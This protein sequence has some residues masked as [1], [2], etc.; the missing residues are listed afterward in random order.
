MRDPPNEFTDTMHDLCAGVDGIS[1]ADCLTTN[2]QAGNDRRHE[3]AEHLRPGKRLHTRQKLRGDRS[4]GR[5]GD[6][7]TN[8]ANNIVADG[9]DTLRIAQK[10]DRLLGT[11][12]T[13][14]SHGMERFFIGSGHSH[15]D[16]IEYN[17]DQDDHQQNQ[18]SNR[19]GAYG[20][21]RIGYKCDRCGHQNCNKK[22]RDDPTDRLIALFF[23]CWVRFRQR[24]NPLYVQSVTVTD[25]INLT[26]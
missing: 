16:H 6:N 21:Q 17:A 18:K 25:R 5:A 4:R 13:A 24:N 2:R 7:A 19:H 26:A 10:A 15:A 8:V 11:P 1:L 23:R 20:H 22:N 9:A 14:G 3:E 12:H